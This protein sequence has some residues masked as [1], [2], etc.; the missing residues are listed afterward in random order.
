MS[1]EG[2]GADVTWLSPWAVSSLQSGR[3]WESCTLGTV[4]CLGTRPSAKSRQPTCTAPLHADDPAAHSAEG[5]TSWTSAGVFP[6]SAGPEGCHIQLKLNVAT[7]P[8]T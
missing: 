2:W 1:E 3:R 7:C 6:Y 8:H 5:L 4:W